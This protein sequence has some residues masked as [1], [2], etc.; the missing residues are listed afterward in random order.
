MKKLNP[1]TKK[2][3][4]LKTTEEYYERSLKNFHTGEF[5]GAEAD[6]TDAIIKNKKFTKAWTL[7]GDIYF[8]TE[9]FDLALENFLMAYHLISSNTQFLP[10]EGSYNKAIILCRIAGANLKQ[11]NYNQALIN[12]G[13]SIDLMEGYTMVKD[14][15]TPW[16]IR[17]KAWL[18]RG[19]DDEAL[20]CF[21]RAA[22]KCKQVSGY[23]D[24]LFERV[25]ILPKFW[26]NQAAVD[27]CDEILRLRPNHVGALV[28]RA[29]NRSAEAF[30]WSQED[31]EDLRRAIEISPD[32]PEAWAMLADCLFGIH[33][34]ERAG[35]VATKALELNL[36]DE[37]K[38]K[39][40]RTILAEGQKRKEARIRNLTNYH[41]F[42]E[43]YP[44][45]KA[46]PHKKGAPIKEEAFDAVVLEM[47][48]VLFINPSDIAARSKRVSALVG[49]G[50]LQKAAD[51]MD[52]LIDLDPDN[53][54]FLKMMES[55]EFFR[56]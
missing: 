53:G 14:F 44:S 19:N 35:E 29:R 13:K 11:G 6:C 46:F 5:E 28:E 54:D 7:R 36:E 12:S 52:K 50:Q 8:R 38:A 27:D 2:Q 34:L 20:V 37:K 30:Q 16:Y 45:A 18:G 25:K 40:L 43:S 49:K 39:R 32:H 1:K 51:D 21:T 41:E 4:P 23:V 9:K 15:W 42:V 31:L 56:G 17:G 3:P 48:E 33:Q 22:T 26:K 55:I 47:S 10:G 24:S